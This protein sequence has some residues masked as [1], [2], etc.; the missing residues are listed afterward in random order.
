MR[1]EDKSFLS[2]GFSCLVSYSSLSKS[3]SSSKSILVLNSSN[4]GSI[5]VSLLIAEIPISSSL[6]MKSSNSWRLATSEASGGFRSL[7][8]LSK[9]PD[10]LAMKIQERCGRRCLFRALS[11][12]R[13]EPSSSSDDRWREAPRW[14]PAVS[15]LPSGSSRGIPRRVVMSRDSLGSELDGARNT[16]I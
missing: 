3:S 10:P 13:E 9:P 6:S 15:V 8:Q 12:R 2:M 1:L 7:E 4:P 16:R 11:C 5:L 14:A